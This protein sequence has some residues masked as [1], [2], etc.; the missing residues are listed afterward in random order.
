MMSSHCKSILIASVIALPSFVFA[1]DNLVEVKPAVPTP[2]TVSAP[3]E[4]VVKPAATTQGTRI[5]YV[6]IVRL[7]SESDRGKTLKSLLTTKKDLLQGKIDG[8]KKQIEKLKTSIEAKIATMTPA[9][10]EAKSKEFQKKLEEFQ[11]FARASEEEFYLLQE[12]ETK[13]LYEAIE[14]S[15]VAHGKAAGFAAI[16]VKKE[17]LYIDSSVNAKDVTDD[18][19]KSLNLA[20]QKK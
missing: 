2:A 16:V 17:L 18:L 20:D 4:A 11:K 9:Q 14:Q 12:K 19:I 10:R 3:V 15:A 13:A 5:G 8:K 7:G 6:D 1:A